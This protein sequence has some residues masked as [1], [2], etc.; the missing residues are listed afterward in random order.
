M[1]PVPAAVQAPPAV[2]AHVQDTFESTA[3]TASVTVAPATADGPSLVT[4]IV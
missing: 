2:P 3:G 4:V 1:L